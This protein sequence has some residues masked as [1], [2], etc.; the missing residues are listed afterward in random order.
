VPTVTALR[1]DRRGHVAVELDGGAWRTL[2]VDVVA[3]ARIAEGRMLDRPAL[4][5]LRRELRRAEA[6]ALASRALRRR[7]LTKQGLRERLERGS[8][9]PAT[10]EESLEVLARAGLV[11][12]DR[13]ARSRAEALAGRG[14]GNA[15]IRADLAGQGVTREACEAALAELGPEAERAARIVQRRGRGARTARYLAARGFRDETV[16][17]ALGPDFANHP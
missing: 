13:F 2:P 1:D 3:R 17:T 4:R 7:D 16:E 9:A 10:A 15:A 5:L 14:Y 11:D 12:D 8:V 6:I